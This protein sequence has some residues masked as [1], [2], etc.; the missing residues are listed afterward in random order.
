MNVTY[1]K[2]KNY[3]QKTMNCETAKQTQSKPI[4]IPKTL[5]LSLKQLWQTS[6]RNTHDARRHELRNRNRLT[7]LYIGGDLHKFRHRV[8]EKLPVA[9]AKIS[10]RHFFIVKNNLILSTAASAD[11]KVRTNETFVAKILLIAGER[12]LFVAGGNFTN[13]NFVNIS[14][15]PFRLHKKVAG[16]TI[17]IMFDNYILAALAVEGAKCAS[18][19]KA[20]R[21]YRIEVA[22]AQ[23]RWAVFVPA[24]KEPA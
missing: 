22:N 16:E 5:L 18:A 10:C 15:V 19:V 3:E 13:R 24:V 8:V 11:G 20:K 2:T 17:A 1:V 7:S 23:F 6:T 21:K 4:S 12:T 14:E 9:I